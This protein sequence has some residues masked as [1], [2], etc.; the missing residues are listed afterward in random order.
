MNDI[1]TPRL[2]L[3]LGAHIYTLPQPSSHPGHGTKCSEKHILPQA[4]IG[5]MTSAS[6]EGA[7][8]NLPPRNWRNVYVNNQH[9][10]T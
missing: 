6:L 8:T 2:A 5:S 1:V 9:N 10:T 4:G 3:M 7:L